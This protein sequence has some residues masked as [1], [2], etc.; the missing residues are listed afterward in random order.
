MYAVSSSAD[1]GTVTYMPP[2]QLTNYIYGASVG[3]NH[4]QGLADL[5]AIG[6]ALWTLLIGDDPFRR[7]FG[8]GAFLARN[9]ANLLIVKVQL[10]RLLYLLLCS[11]L[12]L[13]QQ[14]QN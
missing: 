5:Y 12:Q 8:T 1:G 7:N 9:D 10:V 4:H 11:S 13:R 2:E 14:V 3:Q 6:I